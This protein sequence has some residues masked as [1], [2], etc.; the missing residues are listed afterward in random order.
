MLIE[1]YFFNFAIYNIN[2]ITITCHRAKREV[3]VLI[4][5]F[6][7]KTI[8]YLLKK[9]S[10]GYINTVRRIKHPEKYKSIDFF[11]NYINDEN[12]KLN[13]KAKSNRSKK[14]SI[15]CLAKSNYL[16]KNSAAY[17][18][19][20]KEAKAMIKKGAALLITDEDYKEYPCMISDNPR[21]VLDKLCRY[22]R[23]LYPKTKVIAVT[24]SIGKTT[25]KEMI[26]TVCKTVYNTFN[27]VKS[28][29]SIDVI[30]HNVQHIP[31]DTDIFLQ[32]VAENLP[33]GGK[34]FS[35]VL[36][37]ELVVLTSIDQ[38][39]F[40]IFGSYDKIV[41]N[42]CTL[43]QNM[44]PNGKVIV[45]IDEFDRFDLLNGREVVS[46][47]TKSQD[48]DYYA[49]N[50]KM[51]EQGLTFDV[52]ISKCNESYNVRLHDIY[53]NHNVMCA[54]SAFAAGVEIG[55][56]PSKVVE[57]LA[58][59]RTSGVRQNIFTTLDG[60]LV[61][62]DCFNAVTR[63]VKAAV[64]TCDLIPVK[65]KRI[66]IIGDI[67]EAGDLAESSH[68][69]VIDYLLHSK[70]DT[71]F[72]VGLKMKKAVDNSNIN[73]TKQVESFE[74]VELLLEKIHSIAKAGDLLLIKGSHAN[75][76]EKCIETYW[77]KE[78]KER[79]LS[80]YSETKRHTWKTMF[81]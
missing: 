24:G 37:P 9:I 26:G 79:C 67:E 76:L 28:E 50:I 49:K 18:T 51:D 29:N 21:A 66:A 16:F 8:K 41:E 4:N 15:V 69:M 3:Q 27:S 71:I 17:V 77:P 14:I 65:E 75:N 2:Q 81:N 62:A 43:T 25:T 5:F 48:S 80:L 56:A 54:I 34:H 6:H 32:E 63:S 20:I 78:Y 73:Q 1:I 45:N 55:I 59:Y 11:Y 42:T 31:K 70:F 39:H 61:Y 7:M 64:D 33:D 72:T 10:L 46:V 22:F 12:V 44:T 19:N 47:S 40:E 74:K 52:V 53:A 13:E 58:K 57:G 30:V 68:N 35:Y 23:D 36:L 60:I 38:A